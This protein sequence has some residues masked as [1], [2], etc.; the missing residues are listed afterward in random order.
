MSEVHLPASALDATFTAVLSNIGFSNTSRIAHAFQVLGARTLDLA[1]SLEYTALVPDLQIPCVNDPRG[2]QN[3]NITHWRGLQFAYTYLLQR[4]YDTPTYLDPTCYTKHDFRA[5]QNNRMATPS[6]YVLS[7][8]LDGPLLP[9][10]VFA[11]SVDV[12]RVSGDLPA[13]FSPVHDSDILAHQ[14]AH[15]SISVAD[16]TETFP[17]GGLTS[18]LDPLDD[19]DIDTDRSG[20][21]VK[22]TMTVPPARISTLVK[23]HID[24]C[25]APPTIIATVVDVP[26]TG[27]NGHPTRL[28]HL[29]DYKIPT[30]HSAARP[31]LLTMLLFP[32]L[33]LLESSF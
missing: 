19:S 6:P 10:P 8:F 23:V 21:P 18:S 24:E 5:F 17:D 30:V 4:R 12:H 11:P 27:T 31:Y 3:L 15:A 22:D 20:S 13:S 28:A 16:T 26:V 1:T 29:D 25:N 14:S 32:A 9:I 2:T 33:R 7:P